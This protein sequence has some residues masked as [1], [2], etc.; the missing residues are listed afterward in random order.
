VVN[1]LTDLFYK[2]MCIT[3]VTPNFIIYGIEI[4]VVIVSTHLLGTVKKSGPFKICH[5]LPVA[6]DPDVTTA[7]GKKQVVFKAYC[8]S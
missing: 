8:M 3:C 1:S 4:I 2:L 6:K 5:E 7:P